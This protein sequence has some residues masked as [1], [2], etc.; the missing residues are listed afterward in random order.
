MSACDEGNSEESHRRPLPAGTFECAYCV[1]VAM[2]EGIHR[3]PRRGK[4]VMNC[5][6]L[7]KI[8]GCSGVL[9]AARMNANQDFVFTILRHPEMTT[10]RL[11]T[12]KAVGIRARA[13]VAFANE[14]AQWH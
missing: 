3:T 1:N 14:S 13:G 10:L 7:A 8:S 2:D 5:G 12:F 6:I 9:P 4:V 11:G